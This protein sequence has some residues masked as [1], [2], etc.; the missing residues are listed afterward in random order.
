MKIFRQRLQ[1]CKSLKELLLCFVSI[2]WWVGVFVCVSVHV[3]LCVCVCARACVRVYVRV[4]TFVCV[5]VHM[6]L[7]GVMLYHWKRLF[8][9]LM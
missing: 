3:C 9:C 1:S 2:L 6:F 5:Y 4:C 8:V 7:C